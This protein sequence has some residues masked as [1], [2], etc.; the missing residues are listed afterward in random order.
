[1]SSQR[2]SLISTTSTISPSA[3]STEF[4]EDDDTLETLDRTAT[5]K[6]SQQEN[7]E[8]DPE[9]RPQLERQ[10]STWSKM[11]ATPL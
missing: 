5:L 4:L 6:A 1:M 7:R 3:S 10:S 2:D 11:Y 9:D 8:E